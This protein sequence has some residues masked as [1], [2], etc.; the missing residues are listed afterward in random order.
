MVCK[1]I[2]KL[3]VNQAWGGPQTLDPKS[4]IKLW[5]VLGGYFSRFIWGP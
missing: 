3:C 5:G 2:G 1:Y 4:P